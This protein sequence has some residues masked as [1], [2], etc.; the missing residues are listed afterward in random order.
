MSTTQQMTATAMKPSEYDVYFE[1]PKNPEPQKVILWPDL[2][3][4][5]NWKEEL[6]A[7]I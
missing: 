6:N 3:G 5:A 2:L 7:D 4:W 1:A